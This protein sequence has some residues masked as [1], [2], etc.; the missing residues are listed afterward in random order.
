MPYSMDSDNLPKNVMDMAQKEKEAW[1][2]TWN[3]VY[4]KCA[5]DGGKEKDCEE[6]AFSIANGN[7]K[8][9]KK[10]VNFKYVDGPMAYT[11]ATTMAD[12]MVQMNA[13]EAMGELRNCLSM[14]E[15]VVNNIMYSQ[16][17]TDKK[18][19]LASVSKEFQDM[20]G[21]NTGMG[22][23]EKAIRSFHDG[24][25]KSLGKNRVGAYASLWGDKEKKDLTGEWFDK[26]TKDLDLIFKS[27]GK[28]P[29]LYHHGMDDKVK[30]RVIG[31]IDTLV[32]DDVGLWYEA[33]LKMADEYDTHVMRLIREGK[34]KSSTQ[35]LASGREVSKSGHIDRWV[36]V[37]VSA[38]PTPAEPRMVGIDELKS[39]YQAISLD[40]DNVEK[41]LENKEVDGRGEQGEK[42]RL[43]GW[44]Q[45]E[46]DMLGV[47]VEL[48]V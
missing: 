31:V 41:A 26:E 30:T 16:D 34:L 33:Q 25:I 5:K 43:Q 15:Q 44:L 29:Y 18:G 6:K 2:S 1:I 21:E 32:F 42:S 35:T 24:T 48:S 28:L 36:I 38:T 37:E 20:M 3:S 23:E 12:A 45:L 47:E 9:E 27:V 14:Y 10:S 4:E 39:M 40:F 8:E 11:T 17:V 13:Q 22:D 46:E 19:A 7:A